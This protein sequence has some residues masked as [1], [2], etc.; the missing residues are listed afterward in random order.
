MKLG[1]LTALWGRPQLTRIY[2]NRMQY[3]QKKYD[4]VGVCVGSENQYREDCWDRA[5]MY[6]DFKNRPLSTK[7][8]HG[9]KVFEPIGITHVMVMGSDDFAS[10]SFYEYAMDLAKGKDFTGCKD[11]Y[12]FGGRHNRRGYRQLFYFAHKGYVVGPG[13]CYSRRILEKMNFTPWDN[14]R[15]SGL[16]G[17]IARNVKN[18]GRTVVRRSFVMKDEGLFLVDIKTPNNISSIPS[19]SKPMDDD[20]EE[21]I[22]KNLPPNEAHDLIHYLRTELQAI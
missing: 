15:N 1:I 16:D 9:M 20:F 8:N 13:R 22:N 17:S 6:T 18:L 2:L 3:L 14:G 21:M 5:I 4:I 10:D 7:W 12:I 11:L 19:A